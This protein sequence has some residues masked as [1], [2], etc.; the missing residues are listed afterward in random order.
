MKIV[1]I[2]H[3]SNSTS[4]D[5]KH[6]RDSIL[7]LTG[8]GLE[9][10]ALHEP[11]AVST[12]AHVTY[13]DFQSKEQATAAFPEIPAERIVQPDVIGHLDL[14][15]LRHFDD[16]SF[17]FVVISHVIEHLSNP[18]YAI[19]EVFRVLRVSGKAIIAVP[20]KRYTFDRLRD[21]VT[22]EHL[23]SDYENSTTVSP[24]DHY[25][26]F[27]KSAHAADFTE[28]QRHLSHHVERARS[29]HEHTHAWTSIE[30]RDHLQRA[31][32]AFGVPARPITEYH[33]DVTQHEYFGLWEKTGLER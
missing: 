10:G 1:V 33:G 26:E 27:L 30:F 17:D 24:D 22:W 12:Q 7:S 19:K 6:R 3:G 15:G 9:I 14:D 5:M 8:K 11:A 28:L 21:S 4:T 2:P 31:L 13:F 20:D 16:S 18:L 29:R 25:V 32:T 23:W